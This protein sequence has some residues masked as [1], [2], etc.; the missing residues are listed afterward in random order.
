MSYKYMDR[1]T[2]I[3]K[4]RLWLRRYWF[5]KYSRMK[6]R[7]RYIDHKGFEH[8]VFLDRW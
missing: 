5:T 1:K 6:Y 7:W 4:N 8:H 2:A 3:T